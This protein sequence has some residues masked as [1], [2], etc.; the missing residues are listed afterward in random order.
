[1]I[2]SRTGI[3]MGL[4][5]GV[6]G[7][8]GTFVGLG[9]DPHRAM[10]AY[11]VAF[12]FWLGLGLGSLGW[13]LAFHAGRSR[14]VVLVRRALEVNAATLPIF[15]LLFLPIFLNLPSLYEWA[16]NPAAGSGDPLLLHFRAV[17]LGR[18]FVA[19]RAVLY[20]TVWSAV[21]TAMYHWSRAQDARPTERIY[22]IRQ[23]FWSAAALPVLA[24]TIAFAGID[25]VMSLQAGWISTMFGFYMIANAIISSMALFAIQSA[26]LQKTGRLPGQ[27]KET[28][29]HNLGKLLFA[30]TIF[31]AYIAFSQFLL[32]WMGNLPEELVWMLPRTVTGWKPVAYFLLVGHFVIPFVLLLPVTLKVRPIPLAVVA[33]WILVT[34]YVDL[35][36][37]IMPHLFPEGPQASWMDAAAFV[38]VGGL[39]SATWFWQA[40]RSEAAPLGD[41]YLHDSMVLSPP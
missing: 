4:S 22:T 23:R 33:G 10:H 2:K 19:A 30:F 13:L 11:L 20:F 38:G 36:W 39:A 28:G 6:L 21:S 15:A 8:A 16:N 17:Y 3:L 34:C 41:Q 18:G 9:L 5:L 27:L 40:S 1:M 14:W 32:I 24:L 12:I 37:L 25:W 35:Y 7:F 29:Q 26:W 31:W